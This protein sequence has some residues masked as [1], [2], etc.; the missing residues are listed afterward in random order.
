MKHIDFPWLLIG[1]IALLFGVSISLVEITATEAFVQGVT[2]LTYKPSLEILVQPVQLITN[3]LSA[4]N[5]LSVTVAWGVELVFIIF[6]IGYE[7]STR[8]LRHRSKKAAEIFE[9]CMGACIIID[10]VTNV[11][12]TNNVAPQLGLFGSFL[13]RCFVSALICVF[14]MLLPVAGWGLI[15]EAIGGGGGAPAG[16]PLPVPASGHAPTK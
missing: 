12:Y 15:V 5:V 8:S 10:F 14:A 13:L 1:T 9:I 3:T 6:A 7:I 11:V 4:G 16:R 2:Y